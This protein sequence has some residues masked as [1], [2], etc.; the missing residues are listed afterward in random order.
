MAD[1]SCRLAADCIMSLEAGCLLPSKSTVLTHRAALRHVIPN[2]ELLSYRKFTAV[3][4]LVFCD[5][6]FRVSPA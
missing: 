5:L 1:T 2:G 3:Y 4:A 6:R